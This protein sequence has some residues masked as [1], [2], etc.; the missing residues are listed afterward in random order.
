M[1]R[2]SAR[3]NETPIITRL[4]EYVNARPQ[5]GIS[6]SKAVLH[7][8]DHRAQ[9]G[10]KIFTPKQNRDTLGIFQAMRHTLSQRGGFC[11]LVTLVLNVHGLASFC[12]WEGYSI[13]TRLIL[14]YELNVVF[15][16]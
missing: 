1:Y 16:C 14:E 10:C 13:S 4:R 3:S 15:R 9:L 12:R 7:V 8:D 2:V 11:W 5:K 6:M